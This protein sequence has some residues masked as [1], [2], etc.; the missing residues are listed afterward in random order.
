VEHA[1]QLTAATTAR[2]ADGS[3]IRLA[4]GALDLTVE[5]ITTFDLDQVNEAVTYAA[6]HGG[7]LNVIFCR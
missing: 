2:K 4:S 6:A 3:T 1:D 7:P 5:R